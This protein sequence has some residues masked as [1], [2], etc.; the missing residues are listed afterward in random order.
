[1]T[2]MLISYRFCLIHLI[3]TCD[4]HVSI[5][6]KRDFWCLFKDGYHK[7]N[8]HKFSV[9]LILSTE[10]K[11]YFCYLE[12]VFKHCAFFSYPENINNF[13]YRNMHGDYSNRCCSHFTCYHKSIFYINT[14]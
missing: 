12:I 6:F 9:R 8:N 5:R 1:M 2:I 11:I 7:K 13:K 4:I 14:I 3:F 10:K